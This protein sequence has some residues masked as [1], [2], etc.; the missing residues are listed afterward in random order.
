M[1]EQTSNVAYGIVI[2]PYSVINDNIYRGN[3]GHYPSASYV[4]RCNEKQGKQKRKGNGRLV[5]DE[6]GHL[7]SLKYAGQ[8]IWTITSLFF[9]LYVLV[10][11]ES[12]LT[13]EDSSFNKKLKAL[14][15]NKNTEPKRMKP[16]KISND[17]LV[18]LLRRNPNSGG[19]SPNG[20]DWNEEVE[21][22]NRSLKIL[23]LTITQGM[24][25]YVTV[26]IT[27]QDVLD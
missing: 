15:Q 17:M 27:K 4:C 13:L 21:E 26:R 22:S 19:L 2:T 16:L 1:I 14:E 9:K 12:A 24:L 18:C 25:Q 23:N 3:L 11:P 20:E 6:G 8:D 10:A 7:I 5:F